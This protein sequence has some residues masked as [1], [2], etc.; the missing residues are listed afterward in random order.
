M[1]IAEFKL[2]LAL[3]QFEMRFNQTPTDAEISWK[4]MRLILHMDKGSISERLPIAPGINISHLDVTSKDILSLRNG[5][6]VLDFR[7]EYD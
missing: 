7:K 4:A 3:K 5:I 1:T 6:N 2:K